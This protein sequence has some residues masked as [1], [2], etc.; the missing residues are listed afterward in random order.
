MALSYLKPSLPACDGACVLCASGGKCH[1]MA[2]LS[3][4]PS[5]YPDYLLC[6]TDTVKLAV[7]RLSIVK[8]NFGGFRYQ[9]TQN[10]PRKTFFAIYFGLSANHD[11][12][13]HE[14]EDIFKHCWAQH[15]RIKIFA[16]FCVTLK[17]NCFRKA[18]ISCISWNLRQPV[19]KENS[20]FSKPF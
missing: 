14:R 7:V 18:V 15:A 3:P 9:M 13:K 4:P 19:Y 10:E 6:D 11:F 5:V 20:D 1:R 8:L 17:E 12:G 16:C 2:S